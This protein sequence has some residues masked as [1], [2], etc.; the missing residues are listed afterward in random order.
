MILATVSEPRQSQSSPPDPQYFATIRG[1][2]LATAGEGGAPLAVIS[3]S[4]VLSRWQRRVIRRRRCPAR[5]RGEGHHGSLPLTI[6]KDGGRIA[7][8]ALPW[9]ASERSVWV[10]RLIGRPLDRDTL[11]GGQSHILFPPATGGGPRRIGAHPFRLT[12]AK[13]NWPG[14]HGHGLFRRR[15]R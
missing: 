12:F 6:S 4:D 1:R 10:S 13:A 3:G 15:R 14:D 9:G 5:L 8:V 7:V 11:I 2:V